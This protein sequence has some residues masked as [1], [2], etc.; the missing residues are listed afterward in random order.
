MANQPTDPGGRAC[1]ERDRG[2]GRGDTRGP[3]NRETPP[4]RS[5][6]R[7]GR[8]EADS[9][10]PTNHGPRAV[11]EA[12]LLLSGLPH[13]EADAQPDENEGRHAVRDGDDERVAR[14]ERREAEERDARVNALGAPR[15]RQPMCSASAYFVRAAREN[16][17]IAMGPASGIEPKKPNASAMAQTATIT[18]AR[19]GSTSGPTE[20]LALHG[21]ER[22]E[23]EPAED[24]GA[25][26]GEARREDGLVRGAVDLGGEVEDEALAEES[27]ERHH[28]PDERVV[29]PAAGLDGDDRARVERLLRDAGLVLERAAARSPGRACA[30]GQAPRT[31][32]APR[33]RPCG[34]RRRGPSTAWARASRRAR[35]A[36]GRRCAT[37]GRRAAAATARAGASESA[38]G[39]ARRPETRP[40]RASRARRTR[41]A[42]PARRRTRGPRETPG[43]R[44]RGS[45]PA[46]ASA[47][48]RV[49]HSGCD[50]S[51]PR[52]TS[53]KRCWIS[54]SSARRSRRRRCGCRSRARA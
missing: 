28:V 4:R 25:R 6:S 38:A 30:R 45:A 19:G 26:V 39:D 3:W 12:V 21:T 48:T 34:T 53:K 32:S 13:G 15:L 22:V 49:S 2:Q 37:R 52:T 29:G 17:M 33:A 18:G 24:A 7:G 8:V 47:Q 35:A 14:E 23:L 1:A 40:P 10:N 20:L 51:L 27:A 36:S 5:T 41:A 50:V 43:R 31:A 46:T 16:T 42:E 9:E 11:L 54:W 44:E